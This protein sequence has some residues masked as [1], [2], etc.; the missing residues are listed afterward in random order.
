[1]GQPFPFQRQR[2]WPFPY[3]AAGVCLVTEMCWRCALALTVD[4]YPSCACQAA[5]PAKDKDAG[6][7]GFAPEASGVTSGASPSQPLAP[8][9]LPASLR[10]KPAAQSQNSSS[11]AP[12][13]EFTFPHRGRVVREGESPRA[14]AADVWGRGRD[15]DRGRG[16]GKDSTAPSRTNAGKE[17][18]KRKSW[19][20]KSQNPGPST[21]KY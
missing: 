20:Y 17:K 6:A 15:R 5:S 4:S 19:A 18:G 9:P 8:A 2:K 11:R 21:R 13:G 14:A 3:V 12:P 1:M 10:S 7:S 16:A